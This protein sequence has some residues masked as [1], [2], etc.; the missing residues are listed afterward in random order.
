MMGEKD[1]KNIQKDE[2]AFRCQTE[3]SY[4]S[5]R[6]FDVSGRCIGKF[7][8]FRGYSGNQCVVGSQCSGNESAFG[9]HL[10]WPAF[11]KCDAVYRSYVACFDWSLYPKKFI[12]VFAECGTA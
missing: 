4:G 8:Y 7:E 5:N 11:T 9:C 6:I 1:G 2:Q 10:S 3:K 12:F